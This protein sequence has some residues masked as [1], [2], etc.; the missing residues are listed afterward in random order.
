MDIGG[1]AINA[2]A[3][4]IDG[5]LGLL[6]K[7]SWPITARSGSA[8][9]SS[10]LTAWAPSSAAGWVR[11]RLREVQA[12]LAGQPPRRGGPRPQPPQPHEPLPGG[13]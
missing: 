2:D 7:K 4:F 12:L 13:E 3:G 8:M 1:I 9:S 11:E 6:K 5:N 10:A